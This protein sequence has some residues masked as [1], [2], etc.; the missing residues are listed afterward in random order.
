MITHG[1]LAPPASASGSAAERELG[2]ASNWLARAAIAGPIF[3]V[4]AWSILGAL[5]PRYSLVSQPI[6]GLGVGPNAAW[7]NGAFA[8]MGFL[9]IVGV[10]GIFQR[11][12]EMGPVARWTCT[13]LFGLSGVGSIMCGAFT[14]RAAPLAH[15]ISVGIAVVVPAFGFLVAGLVLR[16]IPAWR[17]FGGW[18]TL[19]FPLSL[20]LLFLSAA[21]FSIPSV[22]AGV[23][24]AG[25]TERL[26][27]LNIHAWYVALAWLTTRPKAL[28]GEQS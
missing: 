3:F 12:P 4:A 23:G 25:L 9:I 5:R 15:V 22:E 28:R 8:L 17:R 27:V 10:I 20:A 16:R 26:A 24:V 2:S 19:A 7:M 6:S 13:V 14:W 11:I 1:N 18:L 21:T